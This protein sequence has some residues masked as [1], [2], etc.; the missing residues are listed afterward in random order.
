M[1][2]PERPVVRLCV[3]CLRT[4]RKLGSVEQPCLGLEPG[5]CWW[6]GNPADPPE[7]ASRACLYRTLEQMKR[8]RSGRQRFMRD[9]RTQLPLRARRGKP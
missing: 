5:P 6:C 1:A 4:F 3:H 9:H 8:G 7:P 2:D